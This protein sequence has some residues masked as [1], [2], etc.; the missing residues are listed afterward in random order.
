MIEWNIWDNNLCINHKQITVIEPKETKNFADFG[1]QPLQNGTD[2]F[3]PWM[4]EHLD[5]L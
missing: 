3:L 1:K 4:N 5:Q 2:L